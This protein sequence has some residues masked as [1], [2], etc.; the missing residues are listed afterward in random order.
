MS[1]TVS[2]HAGLSAEDGVARVYE[3]RG[4]SIAARRWRGAA[5]EIDLILQQ[6]DG[7]VF[8]EVKKS[9]SFARAAERVSRRQAE[10]IMTAAQEFLD[11]TPRGQLTDIRFDVALVDGQGRVEILENAFDL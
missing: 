11:G 5:G 4:L 9:R 2:Y 1:G 8:V 3:R 7:Y 10:R 6:G